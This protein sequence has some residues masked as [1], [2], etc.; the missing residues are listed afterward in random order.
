[1]SLN[2]VV[3]GLQQD[4]LRLGLLEVQSHLVDRHR[5]FDTSRSACLL[6]DNINDFSEDANTCVH[7]RACCFALPCTKDGCIQQSNGH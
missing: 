6:T 7:L 5:I 1:M 3:D 4:G 2:D